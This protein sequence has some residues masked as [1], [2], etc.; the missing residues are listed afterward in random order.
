MPPMMFGFKW[1]GSKIIMKL[2][3]LSALFVSILSSPA[4][5]GFTEGVAA[6]EAGNLPLAFKEFQGAA[7]EGHSDSQF[8]LGLMYENGIGVSK[9]EKKAVAW[10]LKAAQR[11]NSNAQYNLAVLYENGRGSDV[12]FAQAYQWYRRA[13]VQGDGLAVGNLGML[14]L[15]GQG[16]KEDK[17]AGLALLLRSVA[18]DNSPVNNAKRNISSTKG[19]TPEIIATAQALSLEMSKAQN[20]MGPFDQYMKTTTSDAADN[21]Q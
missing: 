2:F 18:M 10:Y 8:N 16:V 15:R 5:A 7:E 20:M 1:Q 17:V 13:A 11:G 19:L 9:D 21:S 4:L 14:Y 3:M 6:Y 12:D